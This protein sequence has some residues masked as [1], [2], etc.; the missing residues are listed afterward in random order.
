MEFTLSVDADLKGLED[1]LAD[2]AEE[3]TVFR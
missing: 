1:T 3:M 2:A